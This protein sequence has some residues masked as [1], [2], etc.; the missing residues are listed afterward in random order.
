MNFQKYLP[1]TNLKLR[2]KKYVH[3]RHF[4]APS[5][6]MFELNIRVDERGPQISVVSPGKGGHSLLRYVLHSFIAV[7]IL[8]MN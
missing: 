4:S 2:A 6:L 1:A 7:L 5:F 3:I 8:P